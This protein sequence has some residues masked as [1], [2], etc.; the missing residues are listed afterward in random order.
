MFLCLQFISLFLLYFPNLRFGW[1]AGFR[2]VSKRKF[3]SLDLSVIFPFY[4]D[5]I[6]Q[7]LVL[8]VVHLIFIFIIIILLRF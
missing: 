8:V 1:A 3:S 5:I 2:H 7:V 6:V 4:I